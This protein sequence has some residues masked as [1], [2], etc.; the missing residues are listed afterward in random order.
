MTASEYAVRFAEYSEAPSVFPV[1]LS[2]P[3]AKVIEAS[4]KSFSLANKVAFADGNPHGIIIRNVVDGHSGATN[5]FVAANPTQ[6][7]SATGNNGNFDGT[8]ADIRRSGQQSPATPTTPA[9]PIATVRAALTQAYGKLADQLEQRGLVTVVQ[10]QEQAIE[11]AAQARAAKT[12][13][14]A[15]QAK[16]ELMA[17]VDVKRSA[18]GNVQGFFDPQSGQAFLVADNLTAEAAPGVLMHEVGIH[19]AADKTPAP[20]FNRAKMLL[21]AQ[22]SNSFMQRV[23]AKMDA[24]GETSGEEAAAYMVEEYE[25][26]RANAPASVGKWL[27]D[28]LASVKAWMHRKGIIG[29][30]SLTVADIAAVAR[31]N[32][33]SL[34]QGQA[35]RQ[36]STQGIRFSRTAAAI[37]ASTGALNPK[38]QQ[39]ND[40]VFGLAKEPTLKEQFD[41]LRANLGLKVR[42]GVV[43]QFA[44]IKQLD[45][46]AYMLARM[47]KASDGTLPRLDAYSE[48]VKIGDQFQATG[49]RLCAYLHTGWPLYGCV[50]VGPRPHGPGRQTKIA[51]YCA[52]KRRCMPILLGPIRST[53][54]MCHWG[55]TNFYCSPGR[56]YSIGMC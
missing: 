34:A 43:D 51:R 21:K 5:V 54:T 45:P 29:A 37:D 16:R 10:T 32:A 41:S 50:V 24:A 13:Q 44:A 38:Q 47:S 26:S 20:L 23:Q 35:G 56:A 52:S 48:D 15:E 8:N 3:S 18:D 30:D 27:S 33:K 25:R 55:K 7:K 9:T 4:G 31:A 14:S 11:A 42:K 2:M 28:L 17:S 6:I 53:P 46:M 19:M 12:G 1:F 49:A 40:K 36:S 39:A 22:R